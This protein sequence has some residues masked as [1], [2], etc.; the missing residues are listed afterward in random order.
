M[1]APEHTLAMRAPRLAIARRKPS[2]LSHFDAALTPVP[3]ATIRVPIAADGRKPRASNSTPAELRTG[4]G[5]A[6]IVLIDGA[7]PASRLAISNT[8]IGPAAS[9]S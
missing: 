9:S 1:K 8:E 4:P 6:A 7:A 2:V 3:P 5:T